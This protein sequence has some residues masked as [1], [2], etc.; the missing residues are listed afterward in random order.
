[1]RSAKVLTGQMPRLLKIFAG[2]IVT[3]CHVAA[4]ILF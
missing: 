1:M 3:F 2:R 4:Q